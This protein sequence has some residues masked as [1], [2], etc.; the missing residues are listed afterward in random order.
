MVPR[1][2]TIWNWARLGWCQS[3][4]ILSPLHPRFAKRSARGRGRP[5]RIRARPE[6]GEARVSSVGQAFDSALSALR[7]RYLGKLEET[8]AELAKLVAFC[9]MESLTP[10]VADAA[11]GMAHKLIG[12]GETLGFAK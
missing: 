7:A 4:S 2:N 6:A 1:W 12:S 9:E 5:G 8:V 10:D 3:P 11:K